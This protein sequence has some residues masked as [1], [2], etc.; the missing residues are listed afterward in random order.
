MSLFP[1]GRSVVVYRSHLLSSGGESVNGVSGLRVQRGPCW[2]GREASCC[3]V[4][5][6]ETVI[7][8]TEGEMHIIFNIKQQKS[9]FSTLD[10]SSSHLLCISCDSQK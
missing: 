10:R 8:L 2:T 5:C 7:I 1:V 6:A 4:L 3:A 9:G